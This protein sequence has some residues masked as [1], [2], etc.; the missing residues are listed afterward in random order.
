M[1]HVDYDKKVSEIIWIKKLLF[2]LRILRN[3]VFLTIC[4]QC[5]LSLPSENIF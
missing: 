5:T 4:S 1:K 2:G 3:E